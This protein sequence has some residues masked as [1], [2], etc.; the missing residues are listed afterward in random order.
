MTWKIVD[1]FSHLAENIFGI[2]AW[3]C[4]A[5]M[6]L[7]WLFCGG[8]IDRGFE[9]DFSLADISPGLLVSKREQIWC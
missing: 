3:W 6:M 9:L 4:M 7:H 8:P 2:D 1:V 5:M